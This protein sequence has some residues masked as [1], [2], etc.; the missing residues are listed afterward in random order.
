MHVKAN[1]T[2]VKKKPSQDIL[3]TNVWR[4]STG[5]DYGGKFHHV[6][7]STVTTAYINALFEDRST[8]AEYEDTPDYLF[9]RLW[10]RV[11]SFKNY[12]KDWDSYGSEP[13]NETSINRALQALQILR[14][15]RVFPE[16]V[17]PSS[18]EGIV[19]EFFRGD[20]YYL[21]EFYNDGDLIFLRRLGGVRNVEEI[22]VNDIEEKILEIQNA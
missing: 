21:F 7:S 9:F 19:F 16:M 8:E 3:P 18:D 22:T 13:P 12:I 15:H 10:K 2:T 6:L 11:S 1:D 4:F 5:T 14:N 17:N 20:R